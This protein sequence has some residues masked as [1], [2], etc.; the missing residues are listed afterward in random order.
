MKPKI[1]VIVGPTASGKSD[2]AVKLAKKFNG[3]VIS[4][5]SRQVY[6]GLD[7]GT[8]KITK[9]EMRGVRHHL[10]DVAD[11]KKR[12]TVIDYKNLAEEA[13][14][15]IFSRGKL[16][17]ICGG[18][19]FFIDAVVNDQ[20][21]PIVKEDKK[22][23]AKLAKKSADQLFTILEK[24]DPI[25]AEVMAGNN[26]ERHNCRRLIRAIEVA[27][28]AR[29]SRTKNERRQRNESIA[30]PAETSREAAMPSL[31]H[32][33]D[34]LWIG[35]QAPSNE[36][37]ARIEK[38]LLKRIKLGMFVEARRLHGGC[39]SWK[40]MNELGL[41]YRYMAEF[42]QRKLTRDQFIETLSNKIWQYSRRQL[43]WWR[44]NDKIK[45]IKLQDMGVISQ[46]ATR[47][48]DI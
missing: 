13:I 39:L 35:I 23:R 6:K 10:L 21:F 40:R 33:Y 25:K 41:E 30:Q 29:E 1:L 11:P 48:L 14:A 44:K 45:W 24:L 42:L 12:F 18:T 28:A 46:T 43:T 38:R 31:C 15:D 4:A 17:I 16:P 36:F 32:K 20:N 37:R 34:A 8:G 3:E 26:S 5:D 47:F 9:K 22:L 19:G 7:I 2:L 27:S